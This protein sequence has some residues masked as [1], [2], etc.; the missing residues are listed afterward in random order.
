MLVTRPG[1][2]RLCPPAPTVWEMVTKVSSFL[3]ISG[4][5]IP[6]HEGTAGGIKSRYRPAESQTAS[7]CPDVCL[8]ETQQKPVCPKGLE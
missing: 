4:G 8:R 7:G 6:G 5:D 3:L 1:P 2:W